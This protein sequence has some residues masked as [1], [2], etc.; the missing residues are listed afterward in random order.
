MH[1][2]LV[3]MVRRDDL[4]AGLVFRGLLVCSPTVRQPLSNPPGTEPQP[5]AGISGSSAAYD[6]HW[7]SVAPANYLVLVSFYRTAAFAVIPRFLPRRFC[8]RWHH[9][10]PP[11]PYPVAIT[12]TLPSSQPGNLLSEKKI[13]TSLPAAP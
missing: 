6:F 11:P 5:G 9:K 10:P 12:P 2:N 1:L 13:S 3:G 7:R 4:G 8:S